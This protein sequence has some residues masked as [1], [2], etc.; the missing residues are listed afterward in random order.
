MRNR[1]CPEK[2]QLHVVVINGP[3]HIQEISMRYQF[4][5]ILICFLCACSA[6]QQVANQQSTPT[7]LTN[8]TPSHAELKVLVA[9]FKAF[10]DTPLAIERSPT[11]SVETYGRRVK[12][13]NSRLSAR[14]EQLKERFETFLGSGKSFEHLSSIAYISMMYYGVYQKMINH[15]KNSNF[16][17]EMEALLSAHLKAR[18]E[19]LLAKSQQTYKI[20]MDLCGRSGFMSRCE[21]L[22]QSYEGQLPI[23]VSN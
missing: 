18:A 11:E 15:L 1:I 22:S 20:F 12:E 13:N 21:Q 8:S 10:Q 2:C 19:P 3:S 9:D 23:G 16:G 6:H 4:Y 5:I 7:N 17:H 14:A